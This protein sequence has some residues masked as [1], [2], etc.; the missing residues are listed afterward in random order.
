[1][2]QEN[3]SI[4]GFAFYALAAIS[5]LAALIATGTKAVPPGIGFVAMMGAASLW[6]MGKV[7][8]L[9][10]QIAQGGIKPPAAQ[11]AEKVEAVKAPVS[12]PAKDVYRLD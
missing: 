3:D 6:W 2:N 11:P 9:L 1:M 12:P 4:T 10:K 8:S 7:V 5:G